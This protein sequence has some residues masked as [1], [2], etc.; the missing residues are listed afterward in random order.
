MS[1]DEGA[2][3]NNVPEIVGYTTGAFDLFHVGHLNILR[4]AAAACDRLIVGVSTDE[5]VL[6]EKRQSPV[7]PFAERVEIVAAIKGVDAVVPEH[8]VHKLFAWE[9]HR[10]QRIFKGSD[11]EGS[12]R[13]RHFEVEFA[14]RGVEVVYFPYTMVT[15]S[16]ALREALAALGGRR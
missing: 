1:G 15:S 8:D 6:E 4:R 16:T 14:A 11:W 2:V 7:I 9:Q 3:Q 13:W 10:F 12:E 5:L